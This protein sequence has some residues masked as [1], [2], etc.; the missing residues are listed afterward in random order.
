MW[1]FTNSSNKKM[2]QYIGVECDVIVTSRRMDGHKIALITK[3]KD[4]SNWYFYTSTIVTVNKTEYL[5]RGY[6][7]LEIVTHNSVYYFYKKL[8]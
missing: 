3:P 8:L 6:S 5:E 1:T 7:T 4:K 2:H